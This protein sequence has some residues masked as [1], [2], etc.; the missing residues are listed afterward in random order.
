M[1]VRVDE[2]TIYPNAWGPFLRGS[3]HLMADSEDELHAFAKRLGMKRSWFQERVHFPHYDL[4]AG[5]RAKAVKFGAVE[6][7][8]RDVIREERLVASEKAG[9]RVVVGQIDLFAASGKGFAASG[10]G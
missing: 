5:K 9:A 6:V 1:T 4:T 3:C 8:L 10:K 7:Q 2:L